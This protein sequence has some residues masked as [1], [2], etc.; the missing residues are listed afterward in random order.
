[1]KG[2]SVCVV[3][4]QEKK[5]ERIEDDIY[6][7]T[8]RN[9]KRKLG[10]VQNNVL[11]VCKDCT[12][13]AEE[14]RRRFERTLMTWSILAALVF[15]V[16]LFMSFSLNSILLGLVAAFFFILFAM[17]SYFP[18]VEKHGKERRTAR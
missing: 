3:C 13:K 4:R 11:V 10:I 15:V 17:T 8:V 2:K 1:M 12:Q 6:I 14:K 7:E 9:I 5:G 18:K 16:F